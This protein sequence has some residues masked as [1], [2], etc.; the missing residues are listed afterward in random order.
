MTGSMSSKF[1][2]AGSSQD[3]AE[4]GAAAEEDEETKDAK[5][6]AKMKMF[7]TL[8]REKVEWHPAKILCIRF[9][10]KHPYGDY[11]VVGV[12]PSG[13]G[14][15]K[16]G[17]SVGKESKG[18]F[19]LFDAVASN[20]AGN[21][22][23]G[24]AASNSDAIEMGGGNNSDN[25]MDVDVVNGEEVEEVK[26]PPIDLFRSIFLDSSSSEDEDDNA[27][28]EKL[29][30]P[31]KSG[32]K[33]LF[34][35]EL[36]MEQREKKPWEEK[37]ENVLRNSAPAMGIFANVD[38]DKLNR[39]KAP[40]TEEKQ[41]EEEEPQIE[42]TS[43]KDKVASKEDESAPKKHKFIP[44][45]HEF[46][47][48]SGHRQKAA[49]FFD[50]GS[51]DE[52]R[53]DSFGPARPPSTTSTKTDSLSKAKAASSDDSDEWV[54]AG[55]E[56]PDRLKNKKKKAKKKA[57]KK[58]KKVK[59]VK[60]TKKAKKSSSSSGKKRKKSKKKHKKRDG[61]GRNSSADDENSSSDSV[62]ESDSD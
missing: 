54:E 40:K 38:F 42:E 39:K 25:K 34:G 22:D 52:G 30:R 24:A 51:D 7:G 28:K 15:K 35:S 10:V 16:V 57:T 21:A 41:K 36:D 59:K 60:K 18:D 49:D 43:K 14:R 55:K 13:T 3:A 20:E 23:Q 56:D 46:K 62:S 1:V 26:K 12:A 2:S 27:K 50:A 61:S 4:E 19:K 48:P 58:T 47:K 29:A 11:S 6:A 45:K 8:T 32:K 37:K 53:A 33:D 17:V 31:E 44:R 5:K 9:N